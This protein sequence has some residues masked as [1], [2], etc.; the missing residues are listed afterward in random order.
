MRES[1]TSVIAVLT[2]IHKVTVQLCDPQFSKLPKEMNLPVNSVRINNFCVGILQ[3]HKIKSET[4]IMQYSYN[5]T[6][7]TSIHL[8]TGLSVVITQIYSYKNILCSLIF[9]ISMYSCIHLF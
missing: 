2:Q 9:I 8:I 7:F 6:E 3:H 5:P 1:A 4:N